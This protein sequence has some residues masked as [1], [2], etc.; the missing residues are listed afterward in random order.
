M[1]K[2]ICLML[3]LTQLPTE[4]V[5]KIQQNYR[6]MRK[7]SI[8]TH[9]NCPSILLNSKNHKEYLGKRCKI[10]SNAAIRSDVLTKPNKIDKQHYS[11]SKL[12]ILNISCSVENPVWFRA[13][14]FLLSTAICWYQI[15][16]RVNGKLKVA[17]NLKWQN[18]PNHNL[19]VR[20]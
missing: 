11:T 7:F 10:T 12:L 20:D 17:W 2:Y 6:L 1:L 13:Q 8:L 9:T 5:L 19:E 18:F 3:L 14:R 15:N 16:S 4:W